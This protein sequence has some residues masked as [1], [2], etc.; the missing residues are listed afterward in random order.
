M[1]IEPHAERVGEP[2]LQVDIETHLD[3][4][5]SLALLLIDTPGGLGLHGH[6]QRSVNRLSRRVSW[7]PAF[8]SWLFRQAAAAAIQPEH[9]SLVRPRPFD[10]LSAIGC[11]YRVVLH[12]EY[13]IRFVLQ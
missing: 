13:R 6:S 12:H 11:Q 5:E 8:A 7:Q 4:R 2:H 10:V 9:V 1:L 3:F